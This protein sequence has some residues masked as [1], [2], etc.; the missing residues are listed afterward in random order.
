[1]YNYINPPTNSLNIYTCTY[2]INLIFQYNI[3]KNC[4]IETVANPKYHPYFGSVIPR[5][6]NSQ[7]L[8]KINA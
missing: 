8:K 5:H 7:R 6:N 3:I 2:D 4:E 1:M